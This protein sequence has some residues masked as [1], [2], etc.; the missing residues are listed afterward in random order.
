[1][2]FLTKKF[3][4]KRARKNMQKLKGVPSNREWLSKSI[5]QEN[6]RKTLE[7]DRIVI[8]AKFQGRKKK[9]DERGLRS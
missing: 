3:L 1:M 2:I 5:C 4:K 9:A 6:G 7:F 8:F